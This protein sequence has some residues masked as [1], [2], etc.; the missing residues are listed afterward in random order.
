MRGSDVRDAARDTTR[1]L[2]SLSL[3]YLSITLSLTHHHS[4]PLLYFLINYTHFFLSH[5]FFWI[6]L[7]ILLSELYLLVSIIYY[8]ISLY[9]SNF[10]YHSYIVFILAHDLQTHNTHLLFTR[11]G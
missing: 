11:V 6:Y 9:L 3:F 8:Y 4:T 2:Y 1:D 10:Y 7:S 5:I